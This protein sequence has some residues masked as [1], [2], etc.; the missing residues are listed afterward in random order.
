MKIKALD[1]FEDHR[2][3]PMP[4]GARSF[5]LK[6]VSATFKAGE[7]YDVDDEHA[8]HFISLGFAS[9]DLTA[10]LLPHLD[11]TKPEAQYRAQ[12]RM[13]P[14]SAD[15]APAETPAA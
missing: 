7:V 11:P 3:V 14:A 2:Q 4:D 10:D 9:A 13:D 1:N 8:K 12:D 15:T 5:T 6:T